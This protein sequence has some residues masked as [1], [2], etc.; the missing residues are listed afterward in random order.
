MQDLIHFINICTFLTECDSPDS[1]VKF[2]EIIKGNVQKIFWFFSTIF[3]CKKNS[4][5]YLAG[6]INDG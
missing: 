2:E 1:W 4:L 3:L 6:N 5:K